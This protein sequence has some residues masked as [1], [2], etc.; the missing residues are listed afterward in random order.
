MITPVSHMYAPWGLLY[1]NKPAD[2]GAGEILKE[3]LS[4]DTPRVISSSEEMAEANQ[5][6]FGHLNK[7]I[8]FVKLVRNL[9]F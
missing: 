8:D 7:P 2:K 4:M 5:I 3:I 6:P 1:L 9:T